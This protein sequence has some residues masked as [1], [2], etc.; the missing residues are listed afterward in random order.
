[1][2]CIVERE[3]HPDRC[4]NEV[5]GPYNLTYVE[6]LA[7]ANAMRAAPSNIRGD[8]RMSDFDV[9]EMAVPVQES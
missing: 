9:W 6:T 5:F 3:N 7:I 2:Y 1:M 4:I 8:H